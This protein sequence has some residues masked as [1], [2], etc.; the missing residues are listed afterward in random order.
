MSTS[1]IHWGSWAAGVATLVLSSLPVAGQNLSLRV[2]RVTGATELVN[3]SAQSVSLD[4]YS[5]ASPAGHLNGVWNSLQD[6]GLAGWDE[7][8]NANNLR[9]TEFNPVGNS[10]IDAGNSLSLGAPY[11]PAAPPASLGES[12]E[13]LLFQYTRPSG[14]T[15]GPPVAY[16]GPHNNV[17]LTINPATGAASIQNESVYFDVGID[18]YTITSAAGKLLPDNGNWNSL[19]DQGLTGWDEADNASPFR[20][21]EFNPLG[22]SQLNGGG[23]VLQLGTPLDVTGGVS[24]DDLQFEFLVDG[25][26]AV[27]GII[28]FTAA[29]LGGDFNGNGVLDADDIN[30]LTMQSATQTHPAAYDLNGDALVNGDDVLVW[31]TDLFGSVMGDLNLD[32]EFNS[33]DL[34]DMLAAG[35]YETGQPSNWSSGDFNG[36]GLTDSSDLVTGLAGGAY[37]LGPAQAVAVPEPTGWLVMAGGLLLWPWTRRG[38]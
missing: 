27:P 14:E 11:A 24:L 25:G 6:Q 2:H 1:R 36:D 29:G 26:S 30:E 34:V 32:G 37:E 21:T 19:Q 4:G 12:R 38:R 15:F 3:M 13:D 31:I 7:A 8:D 18:G 16:V 17:V 23:T 33:G 35:L 22:A 28:V 20:L 9:L 5:I 10:I